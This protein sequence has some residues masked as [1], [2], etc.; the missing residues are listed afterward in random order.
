MDVSDGLL[1]LSSIPLNVAF[2]SL[3]YDIVVLQLITWS[4][5]IYQSLVLF[6]NDSTWPLHS[7]QLLPMQHCVR[8]TRCLHLSYVF[9]PFQA[10]YL[11]SNESR[12]RLLQ[13]VTGTSRVPMNGFKEMYGSNG[14][15]LFTIENW[16]TVDKYPRS[17]T[18]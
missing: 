8:L 6:P 14:K 13:F 18:W 15:Q 10:I 3:P 12:A 9:I 7:A 17:H 2:Y 16:G 4:P 11:M 1:L 5:I